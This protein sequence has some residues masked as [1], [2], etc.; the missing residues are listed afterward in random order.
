M[1]VM[2]SIA[3]GWSLNT[4]HTDKMS[5]FLGIYMAAG[6]IICS[7]ISVQDAP[8]IHHRY[9]KGTLPIILSLRASMLLIFWFGSRKTISKSTGKVKY[10][11]QKF[12]FWG[13]VYLMGW[14]IGFTVCEF[15]LP[16]YMHH[17]IIV[18]T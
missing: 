18:I 7:T 2:I 8:D 5:S 9:D 16:N 10:F 14:P 3:W 12:A 6:N 17:E 11:L 15:I 13:T 4:L 1:G